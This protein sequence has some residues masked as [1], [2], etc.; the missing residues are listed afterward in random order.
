M[1]K[2][3]LGILLLF[4]A[5]FTADLLGQASVSGKITGVVTDAQGA[6][7]QGA[8]VTATGP[9]LL[10]PKTFKS[11]NGGVYELEDLPPGEY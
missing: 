1:R 11:V 4:F 5:S 9:A 10:K 3:V 6:A 8:T 2:I 7:I